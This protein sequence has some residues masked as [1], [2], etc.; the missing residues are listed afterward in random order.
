MRVFLLAPAIDEI[1]RDDDEL[2][3]WPKSID[4]G[5]AAR[6]RRRGVDLPVGELA[7]R[8][9]VQIGNLRDQQRR[10]HALSSGS[11]RMR[12]GSTR[13]PTQSPGAARTV[14]GASTSSGRVAASM[15]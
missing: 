9:D 4:I 5:D 7:R 12:A 3:P 11:T 13:R 10:A 2:R 8:L 15:T 6:Q 14:L 1:A